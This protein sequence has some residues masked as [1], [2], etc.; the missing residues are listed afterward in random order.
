MKRKLVVLLV[1]LA[2]IAAH[3]QTANPSAAAPPTANAPAPTKVGIIHIQTAIVA[4]NEGQRDFGALTQRFAPKEAELKQMSTDLDDLKK[5]FETQGEKLNDEARMNLQRNIKAKETA[6]QRAFQD[7]QEE[8][9]GQQSELAQ[10]IGQK[11]MQTLDKYARDN[12]FAVILDVSNPQTPVLWAVPAVNVTEQVV[13]QY[14]TDSGVPAP[15][16]AGATGSPAA[17]SATRPAG[18][19]NPPATRPAG[20]GTTG[21]TRP[22]PQPQRPPR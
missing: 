20:P 10:R 1:V 19:S 18:A 22:A 12:G 4:S 21:A 5:Q 13:A 14:N 15:P 11:M 6:L 17:P 8:I 3:S 16:N 9:Q 2:A 7:A